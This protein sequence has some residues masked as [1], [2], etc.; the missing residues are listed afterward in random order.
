LLCALNAGAKASI[1]YVDIN[2]PG[3]THDGKSWATAYPYLPP[4]S[5][6]DE[7]W[8]AAGVYRLSSQLQLVPHVGYYGGFAG[9]E[10]SRN[11]RDPARNVTVID[12]NRSSRVILA[13]PT[14]GRDT[15]LD[16]FTLRNAFTTYTTQVGGGVVCVGSPTIRNNVIE[17][18]EIEA[19]TAGVFCMKGASP[20]I[21]GNLIADNGADG[22]YAAEGSAPEIR[23]NVI[24]DNLGSGIEAQKASVIAVGNEVSGHPAYGP[25][26]YCDECTVVL[27]G[28][29]VRGNADGGY[30]LYDCT[31]YAARNRITGNAGIGGIAVSGG[32]LVIASNLI[33]DNHGMGGSGG[34][35]CGPGSPLI[36]NNTIVGNG[37]PDSGGVLIES[38]YSAPDSTPVL[39][40]N[41][42]A[43]NDGGVVNGYYPGAPTLRG[44]CVYGNGTDYERLTDPTGVDRN[45]KA[46]PRLALPAY[47]N[48]HLQPGSPCINAGDPAFAPTEGP[49]LDGQPRVQGASVDIGADETDGT[50]W[51]ASPAVFRVSPTGNDANDGSTW[52]KAKRAAQAALDAAAAAGGGEVWLAAGVY[53]ELLTVPPYT[54]LLGRM[55]GSAPGAATV[56]AGNAGTAITIAPGAARVVVNDLSV[57]N[58]RAVDG[59][60]IRC[61]Y[62]SASE[63]HRI[64]ISNCIAASS[65]ADI[66][67]R[68][69]GIYVYSAMLALK[70]S[71]V[72]G[73]TAHMGGGIEASNS[74]ISIENCAISWNTTITETGAGAGGGLN[75]GSSQWNVTDSLFSGNAA[76]SGAGAS[77]NCSLAP[78]SGFERCGFTDNV[79]SSAGGGLADGYAGY[80]M[81]VA[82]CV[83]AR[84]SAGKSGGGLSGGLGGPS[85]VNNTFVANTAPKGGAIYLPW[86]MVALENNIVAYNSS[87]VYSGRIYDQPYAVGRFNDLFGN[88]DGDF[89]S[90]GFAMEG[91]GDIHADPLFADRRGGDYRLRPASPCVD[92]GDD[93]AALPEETDAD[94][95]PRR[96][97]RRVDMGAYESAFTGGL[98]W[99]DAIRAL[100]LAAGLDASTPADVALLGGAPDLPRAVGLVRTLY[101]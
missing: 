58:G 93:G 5:V 52:A 54:R 2:A 75:V 28:N 24:R 32:S 78:G 3:P 86:R 21:E 31:G 50:L 30:H 59:A 44:N 85:I 101:R 33:T 39:A 11:Q 41:I 69:G 60:G 68:G 26:I 62:G 100:R 90:D 45:I 22:I 94:G 35:Y 10:S 36:V 66:I 79:A 18:L 7:V 51:P 38:D 64:A 84:N 19:P 1:V 74:T 83:F 96:L 87:G 81:R 13:P 29:V 91:A 55:D 61:G 89:A 99:P 80:P 92:A 16:G 17:G 73:N 34:I 67:S 40:N 71:N 4:S 43:F 42:I 49:D 76:D 88:P 72:A 95:R 20:L 56:D 98:R 57:V 27:D 15:V 53:P 70:D 46:D 63:M 25:G 12:A 65:S 37:G 77:V 97:G 47:G 82:N 6:G 9:T 8:T 23:G 14:V 48:F